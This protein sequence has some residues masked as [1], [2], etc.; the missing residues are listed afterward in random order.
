MLFYD[1]TLV[2]EIEVTLFEIEKEYSKETAR[3]FHRL[4]LELSESHLDNVGLTSEVGS[5]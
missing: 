1:A 5:E 2:E 4:Y 3:A